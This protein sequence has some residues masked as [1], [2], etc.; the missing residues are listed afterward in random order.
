MKGLLKKDLYSTWAY[1]KMF[2]FLGIGFLGFYHFNDGANL[3]FLSYPCIIIST[4][5]GTLFLYDEREKWDVYMLCM[6]VSRA[7]A[8]S[9]KYV[10][11]L[12]SMLLLVVANLAFGVTSMLIAQNFDIV[13]LVFTSTLV[14]VLSLVPVAIVLPCSYKF[15]GTKGRLVYLLMLGASCAFVPL[16]AANVNASIVEINMQSIML[17]MLA[18]LAASAVLFA[19][20]WLISIAVYRNKEL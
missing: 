16:G 19:V 7:M 12:L 11:G 13:S 9:S 8:V 20:S 18:L 3:F 15:G 2:L 1:L 5:A 10:F 4:I 6:P 17:A 14:A